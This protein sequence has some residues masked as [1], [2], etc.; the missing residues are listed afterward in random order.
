MKREELLEKLAMELA[1]WPAYKDYMQWDG[2]E[3]YPTDYLDNQPFTKQEWLAERER[4]GLSDWPSEERID[5]IGQ[6]GPTG[7]HY[8]PPTSELAKLMPCE[9][10]DDHAGDPPS[11]YHVKLNGDWCD[12]YDVLWAFGI[13]NPGDQH[14]IKKMLMPGKRGHKDAIQDRREAI[15]SLQRA[16]ELEA[17]HAE[18]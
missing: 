18:T 14:A 15:Q 1:E 12:V 13:V 6:S 9:Y 11:K 8:P 5:R 7:D 4:L 2:D 3:F 16:I 17:N 10:E